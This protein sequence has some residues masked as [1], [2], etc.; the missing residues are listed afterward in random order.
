MQFEEDAFVLRSKSEHLLHCD[1][2]E[3]DPANFEQN[4]KEYGINRRSA[5][6]S[7]KYFNICSGSLVADI[8][9]DVLES[10]W[11]EIDP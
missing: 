4:S 9:H 6:L 5:L 11:S 2:L 1:S 3:S 7:L 8:M 10:I